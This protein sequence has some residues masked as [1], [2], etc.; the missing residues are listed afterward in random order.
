MA[1]AERLFVASCGS[2][3]GHWLGEWLGAP[4][5]F[6]HHAP[7][8]A[9]RVVIEAGFRLEL[10]ELVEQHDEEATFLWIAARKS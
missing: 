7:E 9:K 1:S 5:F 4:M 8:E 2:S 10:V 6:S 3:E